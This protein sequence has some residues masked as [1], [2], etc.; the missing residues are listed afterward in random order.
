MKIQPIDSKTAA[1]T[2][3]SAKPAKKSR[4]KWLFEHQFP[5]VLKIAPAK[6]LVGEMREDRDDGEPEPS[7]L[8]L[9][10]MVQNFMEETTTNEKSTRCGL[11]RCNC[12]NDNCSDS[13][14]DDLDFYYADAVPP[15]TMGDTANILKI[16]S[17]TSK[18][19]TKK[20]T[21][22]TFSSQVKEVIITSLWIWQLTNA[23]IVTEDLKS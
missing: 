23:S 6:K 12:F 15:P 13:D 18:E 1:R 3:D 4:L 8:C 5:S 17:N 11:R 22:I 21:L 7:S 16:I 20:V 19:P 9:S 14:D 2:T 10:K